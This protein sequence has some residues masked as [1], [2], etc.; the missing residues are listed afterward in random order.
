VVVAVPALTSPSAVRPARSGPEQ[1]GSG[2]VVLRVE[3]A[4][5]HGGAVLVGE[6]G[7]GKSFAARAVAGRLRARGVSVEF[8][9]ATS[10][11]STVP[12]GA[13]AGLLGPSSG[14]TG[15]LLE[16]LR[17]T[18]DRL[19]RRARGGKLVVIVDDAHWLDPA[20]AAL[21][22]AL[23]MRHGVRVL[24]TA[25]A[26]MATP[27]AVRSL[28]KDAGLARV[29][30][31]PLSEEAAADVAGNM[32]GGPVERGTRRW[33]WETSGGNPLFSAS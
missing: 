29:D 9:L 33:L 15:D 22:L 3:R 31:T 5:G 10:A 25:R 1:A 23:V 32:L 6:A 8:A 17:S 20:S 30:L 7:I 18:G 12:F 4:V 13:L 19:A 26:G 2:D 28:W 24:A 21:L 11:A 16:V 14:V 27:D